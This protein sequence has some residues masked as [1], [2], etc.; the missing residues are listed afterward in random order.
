MSASV[1]RPQV[2]FWPFWI[3]RRGPRGTLGTWRDLASDHPGRARAV[4]S[5]SRMSQVCVFLRSSLHS[6]LP[7]SFRRAGIP[8]RIDPSLI[9]SWGLCLWTAGVTILLFYVLAFASVLMHELGP[10]AVARRRGVQVLG[11]TLWVLGGNAD[12]PWI[13]TDPS[14]EMA[15]AVAGPLVSLGIGGVGLPMG[16]TPGTAFIP[17]IGLFNLSLAVFNLIPAIPMDGGRIARALLAGRIGYARATRATVRLARWIAATFF[18]FGL[19]SFVAT[20]AKNIQLPLP[21]ESSRMI[22]LA[23]LSLLLWVVSGRE[24]HRLPEGHL[25]RAS[26]DG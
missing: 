3:R 9:I 26:S 10:G 25:D 20:V 16:G 22:L 11:I 12:M 6:I 21:W 15:I 13:P 2:P 19:A 8:V 1:R 5:S 24:M 18:V 7:P 17:R 4:V 23:P 14:D